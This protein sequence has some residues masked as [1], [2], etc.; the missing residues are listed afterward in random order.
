MSPDESDLLPAFIG[1][2]SLT[3]MDMDS[4]ELEA[5]Q[6]ELEQVRRDEQSVGESHE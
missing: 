5:W 2:P 6:E 4:D 1:N 3:C